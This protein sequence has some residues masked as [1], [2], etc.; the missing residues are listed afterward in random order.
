MTARRMLSAACTVVIA[1]ALWLP[2][3]AQADRGG[4]A[5][6]TATCGGRL[7]SELRLRARDGSIRMEFVVRPRGRGSWR[8][9]LVHERRVAW[10]GR[11]WTDGSPFRIRRSVTDLNGA[12]EVTVRASGPG[13][14]T[15]A[16]TATLPA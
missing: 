2:V 7:S 14:A 10:R 8:V 3:P 12:D 1:T 11:A 9:V 16:A 13:G 5:R 4:G 6:V 15:C